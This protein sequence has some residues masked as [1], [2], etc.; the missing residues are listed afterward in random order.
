MNII[1]V[2]KDNSPEIRKQ[3]EDAG[4]HVCV[5]AEFKNACWLDYL[6]NLNNVHGVGYWGEGELERFVSGSKNVIWCNSVE[7]FIANIKKSKN[8]DKI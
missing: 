2:L 1:Y 5:C 4:I 6:T 7:E 8:N 3:I